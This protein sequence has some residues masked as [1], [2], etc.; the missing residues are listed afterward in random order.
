MKLKSLSGGLVAD[1]EA[2]SGTTPSPSPSPMSGFT[3]REARQMLM[4]LCGESA[5]LGVPDLDSDAA[6]CP[7][8]AREPY[9][10]SGV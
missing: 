2:M 5:I 8:F 9:R 10:R 1:L 4:R 7:F 3:F 6:V